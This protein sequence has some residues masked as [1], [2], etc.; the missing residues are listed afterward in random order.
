MN[1]RI[2]SVKPQQNYHLLIEF[3][4]GELR[5]FDVNPYL[6]KGIFKELKTMHVFNSVKVDDGTIKWQNDADFCPDTLYLESIKQ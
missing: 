5:I 2:K 1:P 6:E 4:N 3:T